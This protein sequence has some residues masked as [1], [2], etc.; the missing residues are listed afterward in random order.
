MFSYVGIIG[1]V[2]RMSE[3]RCMPKFLLKTNP[4]TRTNYM[5]IIGFGLLCTSLILLTWGKIEQL[6][7]V[8]AISF[9]SV[10]G[11]FCLGNI[12]LKVRRRSMR[13]KIRAKWYIVVLCWSLVTAG[14]IGNIV[15]SPI[16]L[17]HFALYCIPIAAIV[18][19]IF[20]RTLFLRFLL[21]VASR[22]TYGK[23]IQHPI[24]HHAIDLLKHLETEKLV[25]LTKTGDIRTINKAVRYVLSN[26]MSRWL[27]IVHIYESRNDIPS[28]IVEDVKILDLTYPEIRLDCVLFE[29]TFSPKTL[30]LISQKLG[31]PNNRMFITTPSPDFPY[32]IS[33]LGSVRIITDR[34]SSG[35]QHALNAMDKYAHSEHI[36]RFLDRTLR[37]GEN[38]HHSSHHNT[39]TIPSTFEATS[40]SHSQEDEEFIDPHVKRLMGSSRSASVRELI[41]LSK[42]RST[43]EGG[44]DAAPT[45]S[46]SSS[47]HCEAHHHEHHNPKSTINSADSKKEET[48]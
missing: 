38:T 27:K 33:D 8:Y 6:G 40:G 1:L 45:I 48:L 15:I 34:S 11:L 29:G 12:M 32:T 41:E 36:R 24:M 46:I 21:Y 30:S 44:V 18:L 3:D 13:G 22:M 17:A 31:I 47:T 10:M 16:V 23:W 14:I 9:L 4:W 39:E 35:I 37:E 28:N 26:E 43:M 5:I 20:Q 19:F 2:R 7:N 42:Q 25:F